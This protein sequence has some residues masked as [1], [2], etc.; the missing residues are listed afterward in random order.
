MWEL[1]SRAS[2]N[3]TFPPT[4][5][6][7]LPAPT[8]IV[9]PIP[10]LVNKKLNPKALVQTPGFSPELSPSSA[11]HSW[12]EQA[13]QFECIG[14]PRAVTDTKGKA[15]PSGNGTEEYSVVK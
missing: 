10:F 3:F 8:S 11:P 5:F 7:K 4:S 6:P 1:K 13:P 15:S 9:F 2:L 12:G 14:E